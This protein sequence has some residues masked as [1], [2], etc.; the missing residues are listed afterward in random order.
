MNLRRCNYI[1][2]KL[3]VVMIAFIK[4]ILTKPCEASLFRFQWDNLVEE[5]LLR[6][7]IVSISPDSNS[8]ILFKLN[9]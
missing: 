2:S 7:G 8:N 5:D 9:A 4:D 1:I 3:C 6:S